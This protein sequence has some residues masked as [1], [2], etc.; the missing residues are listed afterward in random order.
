MHVVDV[1][2]R[3][4]GPGSGSFKTQSS[5]LE[6]L[7]FWRQLSVGPKIF[8]GFLLTI[9]LTIYIGALSTLRLD[10]ML[11]ALQG[12]GT[13]STMLVQA[14]ADAETAFL[15]RVAVTR[16]YIMSGGDETILEPQA[17]RARDDFQSA[18]QRLQELSDDPQLRRAL[19]EAVALEASYAQITSQVVNFMRSGNQAQAERASLDSGR[20][21]ADRLI[22]LLS[23]L[24][25]KQSGEVEGERQHFANT[26]A[27]TRTAILGGTALATVLGVLLA[28]AMTHWLSSKLRKYAAFVEEISR[29]ELHGKVAVA[30]R[31]ELAVLGQSLNTMTAALGELTS[32]IR[33]GITN[34]SAA[35]QEIHGAIAQQS[36]GATEASAAIAQT[37]ATVD[38]V[39]ASADQAVELVVAFSQT[40][41]QANRVS[42]EGVAAVQKATEGMM[43]IRQ[44]VQSIAENILA[45]SEQSQQIG[46]II[47]TVNDL[48]DQSNLL[49]LNAAIEASRAGEHGKGFAVVASEIRN[50]AEQSKAAT[51]QVRTIL[52]DIQR[53][54]NA[55]VMATEQ[56]T[57]GVDNGMRL[58][59]QA[60]NTIGELAE[61]I[62][63]GAQSSHQIA[64]SVRQHSVGMEQIASAMSNI[65][66]ATNQDL[67][68]IANTQRAADELTK[69]A[70]RLNALVARYHL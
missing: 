12:V 51:A 61:V 2:Q 65:N 39:K 57:K 1:A 18:T 23:D 64:A 54:T 49:A 53:A 13:K 6:F 66:R 16:A 37:T 14:T 24:Y 67:T 60:G 36:A 58:I 9:V 21:I 3:P 15:K 22:T 55:A 59:D 40:A 62:Q 31:D 50:L 41:Q 32:Q 44:K 5:L 48:A 70:S 69:L 68:A 33:D 56:G 20:P 10:Q 25:A 4:A 46:D 34:L 7:L 52:S 28:A 35:T 29:G 19:S 26:A 43:D 38:Q 42:T 47:A 17:S 30:G 45:L 8:G 63:Q 27:V 11:G